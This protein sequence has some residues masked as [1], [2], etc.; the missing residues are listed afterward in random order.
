M[1]FGLKN[2]P[3]LDQRLYDTVVYEF[4]AISFGPNSGKQ[5]DLSET[6]QPKA[7]LKKSTLGRRFNIDDILVTSESWNDLC[8]K[9]ERLLEACNK[10]NLSISAVKSS[11][12]CQKV[13]YLDH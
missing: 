6:A 1:P 13:E 9:V 12:G 10:C 11:W 8:V 2:A 4:L 5:E 7:A 3:Q